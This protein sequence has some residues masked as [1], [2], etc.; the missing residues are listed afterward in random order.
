MLR[1]WEG[2]VTPVRTEPGMSVHRSTFLRPHSQSFSALVWTNYEK[3]VSSGILE[4]REEEDTLEYVIIELLLLVIF[5]SVFLD[6]R[7]GTGHVRF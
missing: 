1:L 2:H 7:R 3:V 5:R 6:Q 4:R